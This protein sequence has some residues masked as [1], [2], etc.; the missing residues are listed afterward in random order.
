MF[1]D[2][3]FKCRVI[4]N[5]ALDLMEDV[6]TRRERLKA[7]RERKAKHD[8]GLDDDDSPGNKENANLLPKRVPSSIII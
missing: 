8:A 6:A 3:V 2:E 5:K 1:V 7:L 4:D